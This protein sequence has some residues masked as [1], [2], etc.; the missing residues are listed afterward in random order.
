MLTDTAEAGLVK[1]TETTT[2]RNVESHNVGLCWDPVAR[3]KK[4]F[5]VVEGS[6]FFVTLS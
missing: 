6:S 3:T 4:I 5:G 1:N 2:F